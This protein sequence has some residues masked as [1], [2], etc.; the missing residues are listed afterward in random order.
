MTRKD[1]ILIS[2][3]I[4]ATQERIKAIRD[5]MIAERKAQYGERFNEE[6]RVNITL[7]HDAQLR[8]VR[9]AAAHICDALVAECGRAFDQGRFLTDCGYGAMAIDP[10]GE[11]RGD[12][13]L[14]P[15]PEGE[16]RSV[17]ED[18]HWKPVD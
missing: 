18:L 14:K 15:L 6:Q 12:G 8:G 9:R 17:L 3:A 5:E 10:V 7:S 11:L 13:I 1:F 2:S 4:R 16:H